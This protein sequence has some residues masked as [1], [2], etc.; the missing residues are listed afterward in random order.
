MKKYTYLLLLLSVMITPAIAFAGIVE[1]L[2]SKI[3]DILYF[4]Q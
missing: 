2:K 1:D 3:T 4:I